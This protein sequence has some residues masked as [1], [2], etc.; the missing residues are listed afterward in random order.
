MKTWHWI[1]LGTG[2]YFLLRPKNALA[3]AQAE[4]DASAATA[5]CQDACVKNYSSGNLTTE[6]YT[7]CVKACGSAGL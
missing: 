5:A 1:A 2:A 3:K 4:I 7:A 6:Q